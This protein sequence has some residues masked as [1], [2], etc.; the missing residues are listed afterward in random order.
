MHADADVVADDAHLGQTEFLVN[1]LRNIGLLEDSVAVV[2]RLNVEP[3]PG[4]VEL[5]QARI[6]L[7][8]IAD[9]LPGLALLKLC[10]AHFY[11]LK[12]PLQKYI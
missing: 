2:L 11:I 10:R 3:I 5:D 1:P 7:E 4:H 12:Q 8:S 9:R 6:G